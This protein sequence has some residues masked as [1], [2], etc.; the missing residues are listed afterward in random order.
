MRGARREGKKKQRATQGGRHRDRE[1]DIEIEIEVEV[2][3]EGK[4]GN[5]EK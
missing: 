4:T 1:E 3:V 2:E 5:I